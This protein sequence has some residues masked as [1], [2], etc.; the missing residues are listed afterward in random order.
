MGW[1]YKI[2]YNAMK[3]VVPREYYQLTS[4]EV[5]NNCI[6]YY[7]LSKNGLKS[8]RIISIPAEITTAYMKQRVV[9]IAT[10]DSYIVTDII[11]S[12]RKGIRLHCSDYSINGNIDFWLSID[13]VHLPSRPDMW[14]AEESI[15][16]MPNWR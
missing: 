7:T 10:K 9:V 16:S 6:D 8:S 11:N 1:I 2:L 5:V 4:E 15:R 14:I 12:L 13:E 3:S